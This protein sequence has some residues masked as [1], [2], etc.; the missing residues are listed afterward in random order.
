[1]KVVFGGAEKAKAFFG[2]FQVTGA[3]IRAVA[4]FFVLLLFAVLILLLSSKASR[5]DPRKPN[6][7]YE[8]LGSCCA[9]FQRANR[10]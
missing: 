8:F 7:N 5:I 9:G 2:N 10:S 6:L 3:V 4:W 1:M